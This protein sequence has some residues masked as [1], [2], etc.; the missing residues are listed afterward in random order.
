MELEDEILEKTEIVNFGLSFHTYAEM[1]EW[2]D[3]L[4]IS[5]R[6]EWKETKFVIWIFIVVFIIA[7]FWQDMIIKRNSFLLF[8]TE[9]SQDIKKSFSV[10]EERV[11][12]VL[13]ILIKQEASKII[14]LK[15]DGIMHCPIKSEKKPEMYFLPVMEPLKVSV[16]IGPKGSG[17]REY[18]FLLANV[19]GLNFMELTD[20][21]E[22]GLKLKGKELVIFSKERMGLTYDQLIGLLSYQPSLP[23]AT[24]H[25][26]WWEPT[27]VIITSEYPVDEW[28][29]YFPGELEVLKS[30]ITK[31]LY[32]DK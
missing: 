27:E 8:Q 25:G 3:D 16:I 5:K 11:L 19:S 1:M 26:I 28:Y 2:R 31:V 17:K 23:V 9:V 18:A 10:C 20:W 14:F 21:A 12:K 24:K 29:S 15:K 30:K 22:D 4:S 6:R 13:D 32:S 7:L